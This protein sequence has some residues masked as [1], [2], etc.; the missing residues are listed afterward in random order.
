MSGITPPAH[1]DGG[2]NRE[3]R[4]E[5]ACSQMSET[6]QVIAAESKPVFA[7]GSTTSPP[8]TVWVVAVALAASVAAGCGRN[9]HTA[10]PA[11]A[12]ATVGNQ[13]RGADI[14]RANCAVCHAPGGAAAGV[15]PSLEHE[16]RRKTYAQTIAWIEHP[17]PPMPKLYPVPLTEK[18]VADVAAYVQS[19]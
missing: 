17:D 15:G 2:K 14:F 8:L 1:V 3:D 18:D 10:A 5:Q 9:T 7:H 16:K 11:V 13:G 12:P 6:H 19:L 4:A